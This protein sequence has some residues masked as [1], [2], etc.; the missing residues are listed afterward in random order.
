[1][2]TLINPVAVKTFVRERLGCQCPDSVFEQVDY[3]ENAGIVDQNM[4]TRR[5]LIGSRLLIYI[6]EPE[7]GSSLSDL[8]P[9]FVKKAREERDRQGYNRLRVVIIAD[10]VESV[11]SEVERVFAGIEAVDSKVHLHVLGQ[12]DIRGLF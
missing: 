7:N 3:Q 12:D 11:R 10:P 8:L 5:L 6:V 1:M 2:K 9:L 4:I